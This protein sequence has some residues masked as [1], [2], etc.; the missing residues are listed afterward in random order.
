MLKNQVFV[1]VVDLSTSSKNFFFSS[2]VLNNLMDMPV[3][4]AEVCT[5]DDG[6]FSKKLV[7]RLL[8]SSDFYQIL[9]SFF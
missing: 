2:E 6:L 5:E 9:L 4:E 7:A 8:T 1:G 3:N